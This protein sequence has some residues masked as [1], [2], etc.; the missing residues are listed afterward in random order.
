MSP[1]IVGVIVAI[2]LVLNFIYI[3]LG[4]IIRILDELTI[5]EE[6]DTNE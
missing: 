4:I 1:W 6:E 2:W 3:R 5:T